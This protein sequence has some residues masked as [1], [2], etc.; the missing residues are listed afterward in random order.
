MLA[1]QEDRHL[2]SDVLVELDRTD[3]LASVLASALDDQSIA[4]ADDDDCEDLGIN[5]ADGLVLRE[6]LRLRMGHEPTPEMEP[7][8]VEIG[9]QPQAE[10][11]PDMEPEPQPEPEPELTA[12]QRLTELGVQTWSADQVLE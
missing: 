2:L 1:L 9:L 7:D 8:C 4:Q 11:E 6:A 5:L 12:L 10:L 3:M